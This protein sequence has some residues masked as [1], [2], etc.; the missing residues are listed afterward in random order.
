[1]S[2]THDELREATLFASLGQEDLDGLARIATAEERGAGDVLFAEG[3][4]PGDVYVVV[5]G[6]VTLCMAIDGGE[7]ETCFLTLR[8][9]ELL[10]WTAL[11]RRERV[12]TARVVQP[13]RLLRFGASD[14]L[15]LCEEDHDVGYAIMR[16][17]FEE[18][19]DRLQHTRVQLLDMYGT[20]G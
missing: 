4:P 3:D 11:L 5:G 14:L 12:A 2:V 18:L 19:A 13:A 8:R 20:K 16:A 15:E 1:M 17:A 7:G 9:G 10:G 6:R